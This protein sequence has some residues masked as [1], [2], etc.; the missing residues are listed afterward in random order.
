MNVYYIEQNGKSQGPYSLEE[1]KEQKIIGNT[2][3]WK[4]GNP[5]WKIADEFEELKSII[6][7]TPPPLPNQTSG[8]YDESYSKDIHAMFLGIFILAINIWYYLNNESFSNTEAGFL[9]IS[10]FVLYIV[11][12]YTV[13]QSAKR[14][15]RSTFAWLLFAI[16]I[17]PLALLIIGNTKK[18]K[19]NV[20]TKELEKEDN[21]VYLTLSTCPACGLTDVEGFYEC[22]GCGLYLR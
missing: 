2:L 10:Y 22:P 14:Q 5:D 9:K 4:D 19:K 12:L 20:E 8:Q 1:L 18:I 15:N 13:Y 3:V 16:L 11:A 7:T 17:T 21:I 6:K